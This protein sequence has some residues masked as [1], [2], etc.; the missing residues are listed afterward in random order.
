MKKILITSLLSFFIFAGPGG[1]GG[2]GATL[3]IAKTTKLDIRNISDAVLSNESVLSLKD[4]MNKKMIF[5][6]DNLIHISKDIKN[7]QLI[8]GMIIE[9]K[10][11]N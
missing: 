6:K 4:L 11:S 7:I 2:T 8:D 1:G 9:F 5:K 3:P 10:T